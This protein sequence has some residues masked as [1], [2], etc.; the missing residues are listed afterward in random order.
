[1]LRVA[2][3]G[4]PRRVGIC[5]VGNHARNARHDPLRGVA[6]IEL[7][8]VRDNLSADCL[9]LQE[10]DRDLG[11]GDGVDGGHQDK[12]PNLRSHGYESTDTNLYY[13]P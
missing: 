11:I 1:M 10:L 9:Y 6:N 8:G 2:C 12:H 13:S 3:K 5:S 7:N 4:A